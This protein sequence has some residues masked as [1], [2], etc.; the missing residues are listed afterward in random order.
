MLTESPP[1]PQDQGVPIT[2][3]ASVNCGGTPLYEFKVMGPKPSYTLIT[4]QTYSTSNTFVWNNGGLADGAYYICAYMENQGSPDNK[5][6]YEI[7]WC[8]TATISGGSSG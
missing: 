8:Q 6:T 4:S 5:Q 7:Y 2:Y 3:T 1:Y